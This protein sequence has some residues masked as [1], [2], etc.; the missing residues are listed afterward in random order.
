[1]CCDY[2]DYSKSRTPRLKFITVIDIFCETGIICAERDLRD[3]NIIK[4]I[5]IN[6]L[7][8]KINIEEQSEIYKK[9]KKEEQEQKYN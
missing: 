4:K 3:S 5:K 7:D 2:T 9:L 1:M 8:G 6:G